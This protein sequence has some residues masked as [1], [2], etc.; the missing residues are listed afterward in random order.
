MSKSKNIHNPDRSDLNEKKPDTRKR[1]ERPSARLLV[2]DKQHRVLLFKFDFKEGALAGSV[3]WA[4]PGGA[5][6]P[7]E[8]FE[9]AAIR[10]LFEETGI[11]IDS[12]D[13]H[14]AERRFVLPLPEGGEAYAIER[15]YVLHRNETKLSK[16]NQTDL[17]LE[18]MVDHRWW[19]IH[20][21]QSTGE[22]F[23]PEDLPQILEN[24]LA[25]SD[26]L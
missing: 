21:L 23:Y 13:S 11:K 18:V 10:E 15:F 24:H 4:T 12:V 7:G 17:E 20:E 22:K 8:T 6:D 1:V 14:I 5:L 26:L 3:F 19:H 16:N 9:Q 2:L 25:S